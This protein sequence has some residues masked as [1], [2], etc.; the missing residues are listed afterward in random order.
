MALE[1]RY[2]HVFSPGRAGTLK[3]KNRIEF[4]PVMSACAD[5]ETGKCTPEL[6][7][8]VATQAK[9][10]AALVTIGSAPVDAE[11]AR[12]HYGCLSVHRDS[13]LPYLRRL[14]FEA[15][16]FGAKLSVQLTFASYSAKQ[17]LLRVKGALVPSVIP[18]L[19]DG[20]HVKQAEKQELREIVDKFSDCVRRCREAGFD[21]IM[22][23]AA[24]GNLL[25][26]FLSPALNRRGD[27]FGGSAENRRRFPLD[28]LRA[29]RFA[30]G[31]KMA[32][33][34]AVSGDEHLEG[35]TGFEERV[36]FLQ[37]AQKYV[38]LVCVMGGM[39]TEAYSATWMIPSYCHARRVNV[40]YAAA[41]RSELEIPVAVSGGIMTIDE[42]EDILA[43]GK[44]DFVAMARALIADGELL[45]KA[46]RGD[47]ASVRP[48]LRC[49]RCLVSVTDGLPLRCAVEPQRGKLIPA[50]R[51]KKVMVIGGGPAGMTAART[52]A[53]RGHEVVLY[54]REE[55]L[56]G[57]LPEASKLWL[58]DG[59]REYLDWSVRETMSCGARIV[60]GTFVTPDVIEREAP[61]A[62]VVAIGAEEVKPPMAGAH[63]VISV[64][65]AN[66]G[67]RETGRRVVICGGGLTGC[68]CA[69]QLAHEGREVTIVDAKSEDELCRESPIR[70]LLFRLLDETG[71]R[72]LYGAHVTSFTEEGVKMVYEGEEKL[73]ECDTAI[74]SFGLKALDGVVES[75]RRVVAETYVVG[76]AY[77][78][79][80]IAEANMTAFDA[81]VEI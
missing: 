23:D 48:C 33:E 52:L 64:S 43:S 51:K 31:N 29:A 74:G 25:S 68:E 36:A 11:R 13:D 30:A 10:G 78:V 55:K 22:I 62:V 27:E 32:I 75:L 65:E 42:A 8:F 54:E 9:S 45:G 39:K 19:H 21:M 81:A 37:E 57:R 71:V 6:L 3:L 69:L 53:A 49:Q 7:D 76:D 38:D 26:A 70:E 17:S 18:E 35:G 5:P 58:K 40:E 46:W 16:R 73:L 15:H 50:A 80:Q 59:F 79:G 1:I 72:R 14:V 20:E 66:L 12:S 61:D 60:F 67:L 41:V 4:A 34:L 56:G 47:A 24:N 28:V 44:A 2:P 77:S 63:R